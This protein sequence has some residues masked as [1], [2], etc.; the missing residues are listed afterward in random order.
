MVKGVTKAT[1]S[2]SPVSGPTSTQILMREGG[3]GGI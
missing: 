2:G 3:F 1:P